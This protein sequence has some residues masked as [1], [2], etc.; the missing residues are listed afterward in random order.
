MCGDVAAVTQ[1][2]DAPIE[3]KSLNFQVFKKKNAP[4]EKTTRILPRA[5]HNH[6]VNKH[7]QVSTHRSWGVGTG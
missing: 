2:P 1:K 5:Q 3:K 6:T 7:I 4:P